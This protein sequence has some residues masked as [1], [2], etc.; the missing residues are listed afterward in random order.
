ML[1]PMRPILEAADTYRYGQ[2]AFNMNSAGQI[3]AAVRIHE[4]LE[5]GAILQ[6]AEASNAYMGGAEDFMHG[7][8]EQKQRG[9]RAIGGEVR[10]YGADSPVPVALTEIVMELPFLIVR[11]CGWA[12]IFSGSFSVMVITSDLTESPLLS[13]IRQ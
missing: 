11:L 9:A 3:E 13:R 1:V 10:K 8:L 5:S 12:V 2:G 4:I 6:G 7:T